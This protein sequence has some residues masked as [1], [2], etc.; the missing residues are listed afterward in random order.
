MNQLILQV[1]NPS[2]LSQLKNIFSLMKGVKIVAS[3]STPYVLEQEDVPNIVTQSAMNEVES[4]Q[5][6]GTVRTDSLESFMAS[7]ED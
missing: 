4:G 6:A 5:D 1:E 2:L 3:D 7:M